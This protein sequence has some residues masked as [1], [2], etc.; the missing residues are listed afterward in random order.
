MKK[1]YNDFFGEFG[2]RY[3]A[4]VLSSSLME[5]E[6]GFKKYICDKAFLKELGVYQSNFIGRPTPLVFAKNIS[7]ELGGAQIYIKLEGLANT[8]AHKINNAFGQALL[9][10]KM[11]KKRVI[12]ETGA[13]QHGVAVAA[14]CAKLS[15]PC[16]V[17]MG[18]KDIKRQRPNLFLMKMFGAKVVPVPFGSGTLKDAVNEALKDWAKNS[19]ETH[20]LL[21]SALGPSPFPDMVREFQSVIGKETLAQAKEKNLVVDSLV[22]CCGGGSN[23]IGFFYP[24]LN[25]KKPK[26]IAVEAGGKSAKLGENAI[27]M[28]GSNKKGIIHGYKSYFIT[29]DN[30]QVE[31]TYSISAGLDYP[32]IGPQLA[33][34]GKT[35]RVK[36]E[37]A[38]D[39]EALFATKYFSQKEGLIFALESAHAAAYTIKIAPKLNPKKAIIVNMSGRG[40]KDLFILAKYFDKKNWIKFLKREIDEK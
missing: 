23:A 8:G 14:A 21:G 7:K 37:S 34:L 13:G 12:A 5:L 39:K 1:I 25:K 15:L 38:T 36:F 35:K 31:E 29:D 2:G 27:R 3:V 28:S 33:Y 10:K 30:G 26:L 22:A 19:K 4:E 32:G 6:M 18:V 16:T 9:C 17:Y 40:D 24:Y 11:G 20:Y